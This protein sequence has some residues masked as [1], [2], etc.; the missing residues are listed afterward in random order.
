MRL[1]IILSL[2][3]GSQ[4]Y[5]AGGVVNK[6]GDTVRCTGTPDFN[7]GGF[8]TLD[9]ALAIG[10]GAKKRDFVANPWRSSIERI[11]QILVS[12][13]PELALSF[14]EFAESTDQIWKLPA[15]HD[16]HRRW[17]VHR[18]RP[19]AV[20]DVG[21]LSE[22]PAT[23][24]YRFSKEIRPHFYIYRAIQRSVL[25]SGIIEYR[26]SSATLQHLRRQPDQLSWILVHEWLWDWTSDVEVNRAVNALLHSKAIDSMSADEIKLEFERLGF[27]K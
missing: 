9:Y 6:G 27:L 20:D 24:K 15:E 25:S 23:C 14:A 26:Y 1:L 19:L 3:L 4:A 2:V 7:H 10:R 21:D 8:F 18:G 5:A 12:A 22:I 11:K 17:V 13:Q 16:S